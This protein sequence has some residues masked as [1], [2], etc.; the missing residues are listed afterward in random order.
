MS[1]ASMSLKSHYN[2]KSHK[3]SL[4]FETILHFNC[5]SCKCETG[6]IE[7]ILFGEL[8]DETV[9][10]DDITYTQQ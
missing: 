7:G 8:S 3:D 5:R 6:D 9:E 10:D 1:A 4:G 2:G